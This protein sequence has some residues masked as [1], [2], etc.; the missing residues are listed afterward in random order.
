MKIE[1]KETSEEEE[2]DS[3]AMKI[4]KKETSEVEEDLEEQE[5]QEETQ[6]VVEE[7]LNNLVDHKLLQ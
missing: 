3:K 1:K 5:D 6:E 2:V 4:E 7:D